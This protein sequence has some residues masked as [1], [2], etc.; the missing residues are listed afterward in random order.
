M[1]KTKD[2]MLRALYIVLVPVVVLIIVLNSGLLQKVLPAARVHGQSYSVV[3]Y[4]YYYFDYYNSFLEEHETELDAIGY[5]PTVS[6][7][8]QYTADG[9]SWKVFFMRQAEA[10]MAETAYYNDLAQAAGYVFSQDELLPV[11]EKLAENAAAQIA[12]NINAKNYYTA[13]Y[14][15]GTTEASYTAELTRQVKAA[16]YKNYLIRSAAPTQAEIA[17]YITQNA[18]PDYRTADLRIITLEALP[19]RETGEIGQA[20]A[21]A[22]WQ[23]MQR[24][25]ERYEAGESFEALQ[26]AFS[27]R[28]LGD[29]QGYLYDATRLDLPEALADD[30]LFG[31]D[32][33]AAYPAGFPVGGYLTAQSEDTAYFVILDGWGGS[34][35]E[36]E[37][38]LALGEEALLAR[39]QGE[40]AQNYQVVRQR[41]GMLL[42]TA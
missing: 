15:A 19:D 32:D 39:A 40:I 31:G 26:A 30:L 7:T 11:Q 18:I 28:A 16:A 3:R 33:T 34:G 14:G 13:Y 37:A 10:N 29:S 5:D 27:T 4:N 24:L 9:V 6:D 2:P 38:A 17:A 12:S 20:Q 42:A 22:L 41:L 23:K 36:R 21:V 35:P 8:S 1:N 25:V